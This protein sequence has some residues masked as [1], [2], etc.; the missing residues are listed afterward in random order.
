[1]SE[2]QQQPKLNDYVQEMLDNITA[3]SKSDDPYDK[4][5][6]EYYLLRQ[7]RNARVKEAIAKGTPTASVGGNCVPEL[8]VSL[9]MDVFQALEFPLFDAMMEGG[10]DG[11]H[12]LIDTSAEML[13]DNMCT[14]IRLAG[15]AME[16][17]QC[18]KGTVVIGMSSI[19]EAGSAL[20][21]LVRTNPHYKE[22]PSVSVES[23]GRREGVPDEEALEYIA[24]QLKNDFVPFL[25]KY[26]GKKL[27]MDRLKFVCQE[28][29]E[30]LRLWW[31]YNELRRNKPCPSDWEVAN[32]VNSVA[33]Y[34][35]LGYP[36]CKAWLKKL[37]DVCE[38]RVKEHKGITGINEKIRVFWFDFPPIVWG[39][40]VWPWLGK[41]FG[42][43]MVMDLYSDNPPH[44]YINTKD[45][46]QMWKDLAKRSSYDFGMPRIALGSADLYAKDT[47]RVVKDLSCD[48]VIWPGHMGHKDAG[49]L[50]N[51]VQE[52][53]RNLKVPFLNLGCDLADDRYV[54][55]DKIK[56][57]IANFF[58][59]SGLA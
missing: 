18:P 58:Q 43:V 24:E 52:Q 23:P 47:V 8:C 26:A 15:A 29:N 3:L 17:N 14:F 1:M 32:F 34:W 41:E 44:T 35:G 7:A 25:E 50:V 59:A 6:V 33:R 39:N 37:V 16:L 4:V 51:I 20:Q 11:L 9:D 42:A 56:D 48:A 54:S 21:Q 31:E 40:K 36:E 19:C 38:Q 55:P 12:K 28:S 53:C 45:E 5:L 30:Q 49:A 10:L 2:Q 22:I 46:K 13:G 27:D 57:K